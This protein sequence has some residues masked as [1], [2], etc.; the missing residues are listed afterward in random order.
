MLWRWN[1]FLLYTSLSLTQPLLFRMSRTIF[2]RFAGRVTLCSKQKEIRAFQ[3]SIPD[4]CTLRGFTVAGR[5]I[6]NIRIFHHF[7]IQTWTYFQLWRLTRNFLAPWG[8]E[9]CSTSLECS[10]LS[11]HHETDKLLNAKNCHKLWSQN[12]IV[13]CPFRPH[14]LTIAFVRLFSASLTTQIEYCMPRKE[15]L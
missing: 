6:L 10:D 1:L 9:M 13:R 8:T 4:F 7:P 11:F 3:I 2:N 5:Q 14:Y 12:C 15:C